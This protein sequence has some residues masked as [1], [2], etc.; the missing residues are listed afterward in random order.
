MNAIL[1]DTTKC[2]GCRECVIACK[3]T[4]HLDIDEPR[5]WTLD[6]GLSSKNWTS[7]LDMPRGVFVRKQCRHCLEP[8]CVSVCPV[9]ALQKTK[10][11]PVIYDSGKC[12]GCRYCMMACPYGIP[13]YD[14]DQV[15]PYVRKCIM[16]Y[17]RI[18]MGQ[19]PACTDAC[20]T[21]ATIFGKRQ[22]LLDEANR[23]LAAEPD[24]YVQKI[25][26][27]T[28]VG[29][30][31]V[32]YISDINLSF[33]SYGRHLSDAPL[34]ETTNKVMKAVPL[35]FVGVGAL[36]TGINWVIQRRIKLTKER[37]EKSTTPKQEDDRD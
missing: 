10:E 37:I 16:C 35:A 22:D 1:T 9:G 36:A 8:A 28:E 18:K 33:L 14:W 27:E 15:V 6:D 19:N 4:Y 7:V 21:G 24:K 26:G 20:P 13:R 34:P 5:R 3:K 12:M 29:G 23:R 25:W 30:T 2:I 17:D 31:C 11:G 32:L